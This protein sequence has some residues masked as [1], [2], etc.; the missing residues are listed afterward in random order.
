[1]WR[2]VR[3]RHQSAKGRPPALTASTPLLN[4]PWRR[5]HV[6]VGNASWIGTGVRL[7]A[8]SAIPCASAASIKGSRRAQT[9]QSESRNAT[10]P[11]VA[12]DPITW[13]LR[14]QA[15]APGPYISAIRASST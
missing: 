1:V 4:V 13:G 9:T 15:S 7:C 10:G 12:S 5:N 3:S 2:A 14:A 6:S 8:V 11:S